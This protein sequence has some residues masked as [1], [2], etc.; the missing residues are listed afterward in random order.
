MNRD[1]AL[2][3]LRDYVEN[4]ALIRHML[5]VEAAMKAYARHYGEDEDRWGLAGLLHDADW[6]KYPEKHPAVI[7]E[8]LRSRGVDEEIL[9]AIAAH[10]G[11]RWS[12][13]RETAMSKAL[14]AV[15]E[16]SGLIYAIGLLRP[17]N[18]EGLEPK[19]VTKRLK[20]KRFAAGVSR[21][22]VALGVEELGIDRDE[23]FA[24]VIKA[25]QEI[26]PELG[27]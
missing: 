27:F 15:D 2:K 4:E 26:S 8:D 21:E 1:E 17:T 12:I 25:M 9:G 22:D 20:D 10:G 24:R 16:L 19:S 6:E 18:L 5:S 14:F 3:I 11:P 23:H 7:M 13:P